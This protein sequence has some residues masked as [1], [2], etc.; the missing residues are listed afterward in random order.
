MHRTGGA[1]NLDG[2]VKTL[3]LRRCCKISI[4]TTYLFY[5]DVDLK[6]RAHKQA[7]GL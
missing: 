6:R 2:V 4:I 3:H 1:F 7:N 5:V